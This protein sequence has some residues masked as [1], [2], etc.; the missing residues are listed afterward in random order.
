MHTNVQRTRTLGKEN[1]TRSINIP[2]YSSCRFAT[3]Q[4]TDKY[5]ANSLCFC[6]YVHAAIHAN[7]PCKSL[8]INSYESIKLT[9][10]S[11]FRIFPKYLQIRTSN[12]N[13]NILPADRNVSASSVLESWQAPQ[14]RIPQRFGSFRQSPEPTRIEPANYNIEA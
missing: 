14:A 9:T 1:R 3:P 11:R 10:P 6:F 12:K 5:N 8:Y 4:K 13:R 2:F 7:N